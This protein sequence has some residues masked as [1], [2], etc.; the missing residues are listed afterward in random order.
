MKHRQVMEA[1]DTVYPSMMGVHI[2][3]MLAAREFRRRD[4]ALRIDDEENGGD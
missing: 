3:D 2:G 1:V 4:E